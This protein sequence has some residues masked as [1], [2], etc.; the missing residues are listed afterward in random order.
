VDTHERGGGHC[1]PAVRRNEVLITKIEND[2]CIKKTAT[3]ST[4]AQAVFS[5][6]GQ[7][8]NGKSHNA[9]KFATMEEGLWRLDGSFMLPT[10]RPSTQTGFVSSQLSIA[11]GGFAQQPALTIN[12]GRAVDLPVVSIMSC[13]HIYA[14]IIAAQIIFFDT[15]GRQIRSGVVQAVPKPCGTFS[16]ILEAEGASGV[17]R[18]D[19]RIIALATPRRRARI[20]QLHFGRV[21]VFDGEDVMRV[22]V[23]HQGDVEANGLPHNELRVRI[24]NRDGRFSILNP[25]GA[26]GAII[27]YAHGVNGFW[28]NFAV[29]T[30]DKWE[31][32]NEHVD[33]TA[34][35]GAKFLDNGVFMDSHFGL[36]HLGDTA[37]RIASLA[38]VEVVVP[39]V[40]NTY[41]RFPAF[42]GNVPPRRALAQLAKLASCG[43]HEDRDGRIHFVDYF[44]IHQGE[45]KPNLDYETAFEQPQ[46][47]QA[48]YVNGIMLT[49]RMISLDQGWLANV[50]LQVAGH[51]DVVIPY[52]VPVWLTP[53]I[54]V[55]SGFTLQN[56]TR[57]TMYMTCRIAGNGICTV[58]VRGWRVS[59]LPTQTFYPAP[60]K[61]AGE[62]E[63]A[64][65]VDLPM[66][67][68]NAVH[69]QSVRDWFLERK[70]RLLAARIFAK[71][72]W[73][74]SP[75]GE[76]SDN[77][78]MQVDKSGRMERC[79]AI[80]HSLNFEKGVL[81]GVTKAII[82][83]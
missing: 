25:V 79:R 60:W 53:A 77:F 8:V 56:I 59:L 68:T 82:A 61:K 36:E 14:P 78:M 73:R 32:R 49:E 21:V 69:I 80:Y 58:E 37:R 19:I 62:A 30:L 9:G 4:A 22:N 67:I 39:H 71:A 43:I 38:G 81:N 33:I 63:I 83:P 64:Y 31:V 65:A 72:V 74:Q 70:F 26:D 42:A 34:V 52:D 57:H 10:A 45:L 48:G 50:Q 2:N 6:A 17:G 12:F 18:V 47:S 3:A 55:S 44:S 54:T 24:A 40:M 41:P 46:I 13:H 76:L 29:Y 20:S 75:S 35:S 11:S 16:N 66:L 7:V 28:T 1:P 23:L 5:Q 15:S 51:L 27:E